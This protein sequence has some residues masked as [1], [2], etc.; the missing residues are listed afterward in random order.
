MTKVDLNLLY[1]RGENARM[2]LLELAQHL[3]TTPQRLKYS[4]SVLEKEHILTNPYCLFDYSYFGLIL[5]RVYFK[6]GYISEQDKV[7][8]IEELKQNPYVVA[9]YELTGEYDLV[10][11][12][13]S[14]NP[15][16]FNKEVKKI[17]TLI[18]ALN[19]YKVILNLVTYV[20]PRQYL[21]KNTE[22]YSLNMERIIGGDREREEFN[23][24]E[25]QVIKSILSHPTLRY[26]DLAE[27]TELNVKTAKS[28][29]RNLTKRNI[30]KG[31]KYVIDTNK[32]G[33][34]TYRLFLKIHNI[35]LEREA[36]LMEYMLQNHEIVQLHKTVGDW[37]L[38]IDLQALDKNRIRSILMQIREEFKDL[39]ER[40][41]LIEFYQ[42]YQKSYLPQF[43][44]K[45]EGKK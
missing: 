40:F 18:P 33:I 27:R 37:D 29:L 16:K 5:F 39:V 36:Q 28:I 22:L 13:A 43:L 17:A 1:L 26:T 9:V 32:L 2:S 12:F 11:E 34:S 3:K 23:P 7:H 21:A 30:I 4:I 24:H 45:E 6:G 15:S 25:L 41:N 44:F 20:Y 19:D 10:V 31:F 38:E 8:I 35:S 14:P 42:Y